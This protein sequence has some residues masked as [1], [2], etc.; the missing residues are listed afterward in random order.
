MKPSQSANLGNVSLLREATSSSVFFWQS[1][2]RVLAPG[3]LDPPW[4]FQH[5]LTS[6]CYAVLCCANVNARPR[7][8]TWSVALWRAAA[9]Q[10][11]DSGW[12]KWW[13][14][15]CQTSP[16]SPSSCSRLFGTLVQNRIWFHVFDPKRFDI[17]WNCLNPGR[18]APVERRAREGSSSADGTDFRCC[19]WP[20]K[21]M[22]GSLHFRHYHAHLYCS[23]L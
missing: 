18:S 23:H 16:G 20:L 1:A 21:N 17:F 6:L 2:S 8:Q 14:D 9:S 7:L 5:L 10:G 3:C 13:F 11:D 4:C 19:R 22:F 12:K 15:P